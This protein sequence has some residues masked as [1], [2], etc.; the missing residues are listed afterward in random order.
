MFG[1]PHESALGWF[2]YFSAAS[3]LGWMLE[4]AYRSVKER[5]WVNPGMLSGPFV[6]IYGFGALSIA[7]LTRVMADGSPVLLW[8]TLAIAPTAVE[9]I[10]SWL[11]EKAFGLRLWDYRSLPFNLKG[12]VC[13]LFSSAW[14]LLVLLAVFAVEPFLIARIASIDPETLYFTSGAI[15]MYFLMDTANSIKSLINF[16]SFIED[17]KELTARG[18]AFQPLFDFGG[19]RLPNEIRRLLKPL[20]AFPQLTRELKP[21]LHAIPERITAK[22]EAIVGGRYFRK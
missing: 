12:R 18:G 8:T 3:F 19:R 2:L 15:V 9:Y 21:M 17:L 16:K 11:L 13:L 14:I 4:A 1:T 7:L 10:A 22:L 6:P 20:K 5:R